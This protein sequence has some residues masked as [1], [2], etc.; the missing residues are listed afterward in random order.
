V[1]DLDEARQH[2]GEHW[3]KTETPETLAAEGLY[4]LF[5]SVNLF[6]NIYQHKRLLLMGGFM[7][8]DVLVFNRPRP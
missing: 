3:I 2:L 8:S 7:P 1:I 6:L 5:D 4:N